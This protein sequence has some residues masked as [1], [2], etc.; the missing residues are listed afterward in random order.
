[1]TRDQL[2]WFLFQRKFYCFQVFEKTHEVVIFVH[3][4]FFRK[5]K[6]RRELQEELPAGTVCKIFRV[7]D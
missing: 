2:D 7:V 4:W 1:M 6:L 5:E 3:E